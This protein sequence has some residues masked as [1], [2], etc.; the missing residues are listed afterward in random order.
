MRIG[1]KEEEEEGSKLVR[2][3][4]VRRKIIQSSP[5]TH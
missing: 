3:E 5:A 4:G 1:E 2:M